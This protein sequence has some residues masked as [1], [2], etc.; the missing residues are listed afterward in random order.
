LFYDSVAS[1]LCFNLLF[2]VRYFLQAFFAKVRV[3][4]CYLISMCA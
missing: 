2:V 3:L 1:G 4:Y